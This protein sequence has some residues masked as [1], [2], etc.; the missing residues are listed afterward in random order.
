MLYN[1]QTEKYIYKSDLIKPQDRTKLPINIPDLIDLT[2]EGDVNNPT[3]VVQPETVEF[4]TTDEDTQIH[5]G[6]EEDQIREG[7]LV[8]DED[9]DISEQTYFSSDNAAL[10]SVTSESVKTRNPQ[11]NETVL[12]TA[13]GRRIKLKRRYACEGY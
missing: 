1:T 5:I 4:G 10:E 13:R 7:V 2:I 6:D 11:G 8:V 9:C 3:E 12:V